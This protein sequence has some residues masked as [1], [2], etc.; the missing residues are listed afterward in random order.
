MPLFSVLYLNL[1]HKVIEPAELHKHGVS[2]PHTTHCLGNGDIMISTLGKGSTVWMGTLLRIMNLLEGPPELVQH[3]R[4]GVH[5]AQE[6][7]M[8]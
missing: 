3:F 8:S 1:L 6:R 7:C 2:S 4:K 5:M